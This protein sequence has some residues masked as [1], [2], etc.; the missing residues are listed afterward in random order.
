MVVSD[1]EELLLG[2]TANSSGAFAAVGKY[3]V[4]VKSNDGKTWN[5]VKSHL[6]AIAANSNGRFIAVGENGSIVTSNDN[7]ARWNTIEAKDISDS[8][9]LLG[10]AVNDSDMFIAAGLNYG[11][12]GYRLY[13]YKSADG[14]IWTKIGV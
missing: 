3:G 11:K 4:I 10:I 6:Y 12:S 2:V 5:K 8:D 1:T 9:Q 13:I 7:G 14:R